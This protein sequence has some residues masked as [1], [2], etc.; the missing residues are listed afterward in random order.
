[1]PW[2]SFPLAT[3]SLAALQV[4]LHWQ[5]AYRRYHNRCASLATI[6]ED[7]HWSRVVSAAFHHEDH[8]H[9]AVNAVSFLWK[10]WLL[11]MAL[12]TPQF[13]LAISKLIL[14]VGAINTLISLALSA[15]HGVPSYDASCMS[16]FAGVLV[17]LKIINE[18]APALKTFRLGPL[19]L[20]LPPP[21]ITWLELLVLHYFTKSIATLTS[22]LLVGLLFSE[23]VVNPKHST[24]ALSFFK[25][26]FL[27]ATY[28]LMGML[29]ATHFFWPGLDPCV[30]YRVV[31]EQGRWQQL[32]LPSLYTFSSY[33]LVYVVLS[34]LSLGQQM[35]LLYGHS[36]F[37]LLVLFIAFSVNV[38]HCLVTWILSRHAVDLLAPLLPASPRDTC[39][40]G[41]TGALLTLKML[42]YK[43]QPGADY[44]FASFQMAV[45]HWFG[46]VT[47]VAHLYMYTARAW[48]LGHLAGLALGFTLVHVPALRPYRQDDVSD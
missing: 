16:T 19:E 15:L 23:S 17:A 12:G 31:F 32:L 5:A 40:S 10:G 7:G 4:Y 25:T 20:E 39:F 33:H 29:L 48:L 36:N 34:L 6:L 21:R 24:R 30:S 8:L 1:M 38:T 37:F 47:E 35:E 42:L 11:E 18:K 13:V 28:C 26:P 27:P 22:G 3:A 43:E 14:L 46:L 2:P 41:F 44:D 45:P 9:L